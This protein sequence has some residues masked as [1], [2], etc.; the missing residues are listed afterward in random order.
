MKKLLCISL[1]FL[2]LFNFPLAFSAE[3]IAVVDLERALRASNY[4]LKQ[5][6]ILQTDGNYKSLISKIKETRASLGRLQKESDTKSLTWSDEQKKVHQQKGQTTYAELNN[7]ASQ[8]A[9]ISS[10]LDASIQKELA[11]KVQ[12]IVNQIIKD[13]NIGLLIRSQAVYF[14]TPEFDI[15]E[16]LVKRLNGSE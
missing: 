1:L 12:T 3:N 16:E 15:T 14:R 13:K 6:K 7:L 10:R 4:S 11:P 8:E 2:G 5:Y 9:T